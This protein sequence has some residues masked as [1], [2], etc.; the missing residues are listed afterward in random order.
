[1]I[2]GISE[3]LQEAGYSLHLAHH[4]LDEQQEANTLRQLAGQPVDGFI[5]LAAA[6]YQLPRLSEYLR[7]SG[8]PVV[9]ITAAK[10]EFDHVFHTY[11]SGT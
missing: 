6:K 11:E 10:A 7:K 9:E 8:R 1:M 5:L 2:S 4:P 3:S